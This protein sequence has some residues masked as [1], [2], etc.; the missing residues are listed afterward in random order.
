MSWVF[1]GQRPSD[2]LAFGRGA[3]PDVLL[4]CE[5]GPAASDQARRIGAGAF[6]SPEDRDGQRRRWSSAN[7]DA[8]LPVDHPS[9][10]MPAGAMLVAYAARSAIAAR[11]RAAN[12]NDQGASWEVASRLERKNAARALF[13]NAGIPGPVSRLIRPGEQP[14]YEEVLDELGSGFFVQTLD[15][16]AGYGTCRICDSDGWQSTVVPTQVPLL[17][18][19]AVPGPVLNLHLLVRKDAPVAVT[20]PSMQAIGVP[21]LTDGPYTYCGGDFATAGLLDEEAR[22]E[23]R[24]IAARV[25]ARLSTAGWSGPCGIDVVVGPDRI[26]PL[27]LNLRL[28]ASSWL[29]AE[30]EAREG[31][32]PTLANALPWITAVGSGSS[33]IAESSGGAFLIIRAARPIARVE[34]EVP[35]GTWRW[36][37]DELAF[38]APNPGLL[39]CGPGAIHIEG[40]PAL[41]ACVERGAVLMRVASW[42]RLVQCDGRSLTPF[43]LRLIEAARRL[44][45]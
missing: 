24:E 18:S 23:A 43:G 31:V 42:E 38:A 6:Y 21:G 28:Q 45:I 17:A 30:R 19:A 13:A 36:R 44:F 22:A 41:G 14:S 12:M 25:G 8:A 10:V 3:R 40:A 1:V 16:S 27:E 15:G 32:S 4:S 20:A 7:L 39:E 33:S 29:L 5:G 9:K 11:V 35:T 37:G 34:C 26:V 2:V